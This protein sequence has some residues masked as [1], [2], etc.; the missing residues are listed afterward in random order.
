MKPVIVLTLVTKF[1]LELAALASLY[2]WRGIIP[3]IVFALF[4]GFVLSP[5]SRI[6]MPRI[7]RALLGAAALIAAFATLAF[8]GQPRVSAVLSA[9]A[10]VDAVMIILFKA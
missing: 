7:V 4:W 2:Y 9:I 6:Q 1:L 5:K 8:V 10:L 3:P